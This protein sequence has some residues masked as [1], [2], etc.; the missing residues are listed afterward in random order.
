MMPRGSAD[1]RGEQIAAI[2]T[3][4]HALLTSPRVSR[5]LDR[6]QAAEGA[7]SDWERANLRGMRVSVTTP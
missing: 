1:V 7:L 4:Q 6:A 5:L 3:E 2:Q